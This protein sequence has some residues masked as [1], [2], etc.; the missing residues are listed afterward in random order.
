MSVSPVPLSHLD[1]IIFDFGG[2]LLPLDFEAT[3]VALSELLGADAG[4][5]Y[6]RWDQ[7]E[8]FDALETGK[9]HRHEFCERLWNLA[10][11]H[12][13]D[14]ARRRIY[15][16]NVEDAFNALLGDVPEENLDLLERLG[17]KRRLFLLSNINEIH[18]DGVMAN[19]RR[20]HPTRGAWDDHF[21]A[22]HYSHLMGL[23]KPDPQIYQRV[24]DEHGLAPKR[25]L[26]LDDNPDNIAAAARLGI[27]AQLHPR[28]A[29]LVPWF[30][31]ESP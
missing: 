5:F 17:K 3:V 27:V 23:R 14:A 12:P 10:A 11:T 25:T 18:H 31:E 20:A 1:A 19:Y 7:T 29:P 28:N 30:A 2:V 8:L 9:L 15:D 4:E 26:F 24:L 21:E 13:R 22:V 16:A 6:S